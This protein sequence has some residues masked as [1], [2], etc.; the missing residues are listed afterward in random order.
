VSL[1]RFVVPDWAAP[2]RVHAAT[3][4]RAWPGDWRDPEARARLRREL[5][6][7]SEPRWLRQVHGTGVVD[8][9]EVARLAVEPEADAAIT[10]APGVVLAVRTA[11]CLPILLAAADG[12]AVAAIH[13]GWRGLA[14]GV[15]ESTVARWPASPETTLAWIGPAAG[16]SAYEVDAAVRTAFVG[17]DP[18][19]AEG[20]RDSR[21]GHWWCDLPALA[22]R[23]LAALGIVRV[24][25]S[26]RCTISESDTFYSW[27]RAAEPGRMATL[28]WIGG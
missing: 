26:D 7:P 15:I 9:A 24:S 8:D 22:R 13:A 5:A 4:T 18:A 25:G 1:P 21:P 17:P 28:V 19:A 23:R 6:L 20:F 14:A 11:D 27:R 16:A 2:P 12:S 10:R 3:T